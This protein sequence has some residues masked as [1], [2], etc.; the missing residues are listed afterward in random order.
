MV[1]INTAAV[2]REELQAVIVQGRGVNSQNIWKQIL[3][4]YPVTK[5]NGHLI[6]MTIQ[7]AELMRIM[8][9]IV[10]PGQR[11]ER[12]TLSFGDSSYTISLRKEE[13]AIPDEVEKEYD[14]Y[15]STEA[16]ASQKG[17]EKLELTLEYLCAAQI[18]NTTNFGSATN[19]AVAYTNANLATISFIADVYA[20]I[21]L[22]RQ[23]GEE[24]NTIII[25]DLVYQRIRQASLVV[26][27]VRGQLSAQQEVN[28]N[29][30]QK[31]FEDEGIKKVLISRSR[32][33]T[34]APNAT[35]PS[36]TKI[37]PVTYIWVG[38]TGDSFIEEDGSIATISGA[39]GMLYWDAFG[40]TQ[41]MTYR[42]E[43][44]MSNIVRA[45]SSAVPYI[46]NTNAGTLV[47]TQYS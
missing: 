11:P 18:F 33:N 5:L 38:V 1:Y 8:D 29:T 14:D 19:S 13:I 21:E 28:T 26:S 16:F 37:Y 42:D 7:A 24:P 34:A 17:Q 43:T 10:Q 2:P 32:Y 40:S 4:E 39:G 44:V 45:L 22:V 25:P 41:I 9:K 46:A 15:F 23:Q 6:S 20:A 30:I 27:F 3:P 36:F 12:I 35:V 47:A 31:A